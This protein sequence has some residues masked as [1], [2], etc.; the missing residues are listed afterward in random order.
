MNSLKSLIKPKYSIIAVTLLLAVSTFILLFKLM[1]PINQTASLA[2]GI[3][4]NLQVFDSEN[5]ADWSIQQNLQVNDLR[6]GDR[7]YRFTSVAN[8]AGNDWIRTA[9]DSKYSLLNPLASFV[10][11]QNAIVYI[12]HDDRIG[13]KPSW[14]SGWSDTGMNL[15]DTDSSS[16]NFSIFS[17]SF[18]AGQTVNLGP[19]ASSVVERSSSYTVTVVAVA[20]ITP[21]TSPIPTPIEGPVNN[22]G[23]IPRVLTAEEQVIN[24]EAT[25]LFNLIPVPG[26]SFII[27]FDYRKDKYWVKLFG[28]NSKEDLD[29][30][31][32]D[33]K[34]NEIPADYYLIDGPPANPGDSN[35]D[36]YIDGE[37]FIVWFNNFG[38]STTEG[39][40][41]G[42]YYTE[43]VIDIKDYL[44]WISS[45]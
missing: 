6:F 12:A 17:K 35:N 10:V 4:S 39:V 5:A 33:K 28:R 36:N 25:A 30:W 13:T 19:N 40:S 1:D 21:I 14:L 24:D 23:Y 15:T 42:D 11:T 43:G 38:K 3:I 9:V 45:F 7:S 16:G 31:I 8:L 37:D 34:M 41:K 22:T 26:S 32:S 27:E 44:I 18:S 2:A 20:T 29:K